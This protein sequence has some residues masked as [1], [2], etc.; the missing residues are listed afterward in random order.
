MLAWFHSAP[1]G[2]VSLLTAFMAA[3]VALAVVVLTQWILNR[4]QRAELLAKKLEEI[5][6]LLN[7]AASD[8][9]QRY[10]AIFAKLRNGAETSPAGLEPSAYHLDLHKKIVMYVR[11]YF[12]LLG[13][14]HQHM[15]RCNNRISWIVHRLAS[16]EQVEQKDVL[17]AFGAYGDSL[18]NLEQEIIDN[19]SLLVGDRAWPRRYKVANNHTPVPD[20]A[21]GL[22]P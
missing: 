8:N 17:E 11:L 16:G 10:Q 4:R 7:Q 15:F 19:K 2:L 1:A 5:Y 6:V 14:A 21:E 12:P 18:R 9:I 20:T 13:P 3:F 22:N